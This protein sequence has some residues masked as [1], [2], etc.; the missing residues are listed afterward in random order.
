MCRKCLPHLGRDLWASLAGR[1]LLSLTSARGGSLLQSACLL[2]LLSRPALGVCRGP[3]PGSSLRGDLAP[4]PPRSIAVVGVPAVLPRAWSLHA[5]VSR[6][7]RA[8]ARAAAQVQDSENVE[9]PSWGTWVT[10]AV[11]AP[12]LVAF[13]PPAVDSAQGLHLCRLPSIWA[14][15]SPPHAPECAPRHTGWGEPR[16]GAQSH[17]EDPHVPPVGL[18]PRP[19]G[20]GPFLCPRSPRVWPSRLQRARIDLAGSS[21]GR[22]GAGAQ[23]C[24][25]S[26]FTSSRRPWWEAC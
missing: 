7:S 13:C 19:A 21:S 17:P 18:R 16:C 4:P 3:G 26:H 23:W 5:G 25:L 6:P 22:G 20:A 11:G 8:W 24:Q 9:A 14:H 12:G 15:G 10:A 2:P 1:P